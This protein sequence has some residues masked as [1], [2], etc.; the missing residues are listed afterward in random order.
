MIV[1]LLYKKMFDALSPIEF[2]QAIG[3]PS[4]SAIAV[5]SDSLSDMND[6]AV[7][8]HMVAFFLALSTVYPAM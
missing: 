6:T 4:N 8:F 5:N 3:E 7:P 1:P 2:P